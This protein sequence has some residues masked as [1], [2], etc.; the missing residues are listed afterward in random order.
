MENYIVDN[1]IYT[2]AK[3]KN[4]DNVTNIEIQDIVF[5]I[6]LEIDRVC[7]KNNIPYALSF[8]SALGLNNYGSFIPWDDD[9]DISME[10]SDYLRFVEALSKD[11][12]EDFT[13]EC[14][15][16][17]NRSVVVIPAMKVR[18]KHS[19]I[20]E[21]NNFTLPNRTKRGNGIFVDVSPLI[22]VPNNEK[23]H[24]KLIWKSKWSL[25]PFM[26]FETLLHINL[27]GLKK[28]LKTFEKEVNEKYVDSGF[29]SQSVIIPFQ[30]YP[31]KIVEHLAFP[32]EIIYPF[33]EYEFHGVKLYSFNNVEEFC[34]LR[35]GEKSLKKWDGNNYL[36]PFNKKDAG[37]HLRIV[38]IY[39]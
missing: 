36:A 8:G 10:Y 13:F 3:N 24:K 18:Y 11:I 1:N 17:D 23:E 14:Y 12:G 15:E 35:Y 7:R 31:K 37:E 5:K 27:K 34:R 19:F 25:I 32:K 28:R 21:K 4:K 2:L 9:A 33:K 6:V 38:E 30:E 26:L 20:K 29:V 22:N 16:V 39:K